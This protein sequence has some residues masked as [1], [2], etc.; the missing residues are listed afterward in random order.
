M[1][2]S[3]SG[4]NH[5]KP[6]VNGTHPLLIGPS[7]QWSFCGAWVFL[8]NDPIFSRRTW[9]WTTALCHVPWA[10]EVSHEAWMTL[11]RRMMKTVVIAPEGEEASPVG[12]LMKSFRC[13]YKGIT[14]QLSSYLSPLSCYHCF[15]KLLYII[16]PSIQLC[17]YCLFLGL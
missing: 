3:Q 5:K 1:W 14:I 15:L 4:A 17:T 13:K 6:E 10:A 9:T 8:L 16:G 2:G 7:P 12:C 11:R